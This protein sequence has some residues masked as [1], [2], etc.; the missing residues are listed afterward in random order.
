MTL[1][2]QAYGIQEIVR[3][4][5]FSITSLLKYLEKQSPLKIV[6]YTDAPKSIESFFKNENRVEIVVIDQK[7]IKTWRGEIDFVHRVKIEILRDAGSKFPGNL[8]YCDGDTYFTKSPSEKFKLVDDKTSLMHICESTLGDEK[9]PIAKKMNRFVR[10]NKFTVAGQ[11]SGLSEK[12]QMWNAGVIGISQKNKILLEDIL[13]LTDQ[14]HRIYPKHVNEQLAVSQILK[15]HTEICASDDV[16]IHYWNQKEEYQKAIDIFLEN[17]GE[18]QLAMANYH[19]FE[20]PAPPKRGLSKM[21]S[22]LFR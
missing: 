11:D 8:Y 4:T 19:T 1:V 2:Y 10:E 20:K 21:W 15:N 5:L 12:S 6:I 14:M 22:K 3:Q 7:I 18:I 9:D 13:D 17:F 16:I